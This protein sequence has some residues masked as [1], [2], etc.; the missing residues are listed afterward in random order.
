MHVTENQFFHIGKKLRKKYFALQG[1][2][3]PQGGLQGGSPPGGAAG[4]CRAIIFERKALIG[5]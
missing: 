3:V 4:G 2:V 5:V 1:G